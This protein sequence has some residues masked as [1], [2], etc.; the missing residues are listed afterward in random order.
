MFHYHRK[1]HDI[2]LGTLCNYGC[3]N[4]AT[5]RS[6]SGKYCSVSKFSN[7]PAYVTIQKERVTE[8][9]KRPESNERRR[10]TGIETKNRLCNSENYKKV[11]DTRRKKTG[12]LTEERRKVFR[13]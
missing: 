7:C 11:S 2:E 4:L 5:S 10:K 13:R 3:G 12:L 8:H 6:T 9:W 1:T